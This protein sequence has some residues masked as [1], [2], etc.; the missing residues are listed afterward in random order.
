M[1]DITEYQDVIDLAMAELTK[2]GYS[3]VS[4]NVMTDYLHN[5]YCSQDDYDLYTDV[6]SSVIIRYSLAD[7]QQLNA[8]KRLEKRFKQIVL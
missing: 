4:Y 8:A 6:W 1:Y 2:R 5:G 3:N 7:W